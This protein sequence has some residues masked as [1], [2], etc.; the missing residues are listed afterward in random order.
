MDSPWQ[1]FSV[2]K[3]ECLTQP[4]KVQLS[5]KLKVFSDFC[6]QF[7]KYMSNFEYFFKKRWAS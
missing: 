6:A 3:N 7:V 1:V 4:M 2:G 5:R